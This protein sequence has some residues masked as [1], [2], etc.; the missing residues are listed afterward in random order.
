MTFEDYVAQIATIR[1]LLESPVLVTEQR[2]VDGFGGGHDVGAPVVSWE[3]LPADGPVGGA[4][5][6]PDDLAFVQYSSGSTSAPKGCMLSARAIGR[7]LETIAEISDPTPGEETVAS[8]LPL[9][10]DMGVCTGRR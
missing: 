7:Q 1:G 5:P 8:W 3:S 10:H 4:P 6:G 9:S 2:L